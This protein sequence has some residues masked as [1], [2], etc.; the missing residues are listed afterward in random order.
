LTAATELPLE[1]PEPRDAGPK[2][3]ERFMLDA[4]HRR[5]GQ[6]HGNGP[7]F[8]VAEHVKSGGAFDAKRTA[9]LIAVD[10]WKT[11][12]YEVHGHEVKTS[13]SDWLRELK[14]PEKAA[15]FAPYVN[16]W[17]IVVADRR[18]VREGELAPGWGLLVLGDCQHLVTAVK[19]RRT[20]ALP[21]PP[22]R[23]AA[24]LRAT[25]KTAARRA[26]S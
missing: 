25:A 20:E 8:V 19:A 24:L 7:R 4:L 10:M 17:W 12:R 6:Y 22:D 3:T 2:V 23:L 11:G 5:Y 1:I 13:R 16:R 21:L 15:E 18:I 14:Q 9:D 26:A